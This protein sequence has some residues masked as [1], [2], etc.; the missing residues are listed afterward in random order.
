MAH[1]RRDVTE[2]HRG[3]SVGEDLHAPLH[4]SRL[5]LKFIHVGE[6]SGSTNDTIGA[7]VTQREAL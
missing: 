7:A 1:Y 2:L 6:A 3:M 5:T 4:P